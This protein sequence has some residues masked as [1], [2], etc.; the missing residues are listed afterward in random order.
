VAR[1]SRL[2]TSFARMPATISVAL[3]SAHSV[4]YAS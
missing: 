2:D 4:M 3:R 1:T